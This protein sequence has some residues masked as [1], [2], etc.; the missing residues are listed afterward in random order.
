MSGCPWDRFGPTAENLK[1]T[2]F[3]AIF[4]CDYPATTSRQPSSRTDNPRL[5][6]RQP[7][8]VAPNVQLPPCD[9]LG[10]RT[11]RGGCRNVRLGVACHGL[12]L[13]RPGAST[14][15]MGVPTQYPR[16]RPGTPFVF[17]GS[18]PSINSYLPR[19]WTGACLKR[20]PRKVILEPLQLVLRKVRKI[21]WGPEPSLKRGPGGLDERGCES[22]RSPRPSFSQP[23]V[24]SSG[25]RSRSMQPPS[26]SRQTH[27][28]ATWPTW[29][30]MLG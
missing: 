16:K 30:C 29:S 19:L 15:G 26:G 22:P 6:H 10:S 4:G 14:C 9:N 8:V 11:S 21:L 7:G 18:T 20:D 5:S 12:V 1:T 2:P 3:L 27:S 24:P 23:C 25:P 13:G 28:C 17:L